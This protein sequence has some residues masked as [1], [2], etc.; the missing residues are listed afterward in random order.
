MPGLQQA[1]HEAL[2]TPVGKGPAGLPQGEEVAKAQAEKILRCQHADG[3]IVEGERARR[4]QP[5][6]AKDVST[7]GM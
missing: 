2:A 6:Q 5:V 3:P 4:L 1:G 7:T